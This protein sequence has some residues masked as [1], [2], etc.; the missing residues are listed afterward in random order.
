MS[1]LSKNEQ[2]EIAKKLEYLLC[3]VLLRCDGYFV[4]AYL[5]RVSKNRLAIVVFVD[6]NVKGEWIDSNPENVSEEAKRFFRPS[7]RALYNAKE[8]KRYEMV[9]GKRECKK[10]GGYKKIVI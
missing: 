2:S 9:L 8:I 3:D 10:W 6:G 5:D 7:L 1:R 4:K